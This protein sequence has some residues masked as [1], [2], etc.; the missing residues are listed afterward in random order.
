M[1]TCVDPDGN[2]DNMLP[3]IG[4]HTVDAVTGVCALHAML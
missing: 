3:S 1:L 4:G 2:P